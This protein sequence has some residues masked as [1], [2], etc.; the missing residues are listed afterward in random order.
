MKQINIQKDKNDSYMSG[1]LPIII[2]KDVSFSYNGE[3]IFESVN[4]EILHKEFL[5]IIG[6][7]GGGKTTF[8]KILLGLLPDFTGEISYPNRE[9]FTS[10]KEIGYVPQNTQINIDFPIMV[11]EIVEMGILETRVFGY[12]VN[13]KLRMQ[14]FE[15]LSK[16]GI[17]NLAYKKISDLS[18]GQ[19]QRVFIARALIGNP[20]LLILDEPTSNIDIQT[21]VEIYKI[22]KTI[23]EFHTIIT[24]SHDIPITLEYAT[25][26]LHINRAIH[27]HETPHITLNKDGHICEIDIFQDFAKNYNEGGLS[28]ERV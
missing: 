17:E 19:R 5:G 16:L 15:I 7:N 2:G 11:I 27:S 25:R 6:P 10:K 28:N 8:I 21:Q 23:N 20:K 12:R 3:K 9:L 14:A 22:L 4:F 26:I 13:K 1:N 24:I 18:G